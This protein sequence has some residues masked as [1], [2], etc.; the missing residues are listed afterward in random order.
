MITAETLAK[1]GYSEEALREKF[2]PA[3]GAE[4]D[5][6]IKD[7]CDLMASRIRGAVDMAS[8]TAEI[9]F[10]VDEAIQTPLRQLGYTLARHFHE[11]SVGGVVSMNDVASIA[12]DWGF[13]GMIQPVL[14]ETG[15]PLSSRDGNPIYA[16]DLPI[17]TNIFFPAVL[18]YCTAQWANLFN[19][20]D[21]HPLYKYPPAI[22]TPKNKAKCDILTSRADRMTRDMGYR[23]DERQA[24]WQSVVYGSCLKVPREPYYRHYEIVGAETQVDP[25]DPTKTVTVPVKRIVREGVRWSLAHPT[26]TIMDYAH[27][28]STVNSDT[29]AEFYGTYEIY[30]WGDVKKNKEFWLDTERG[31]VDRVVGTSNT[32]FHS[33]S[34]QRM[35]NIL[36]PC[37]MKFPDWG[38]STSTDREEWAHDFSTHQDDQGVPLCNVYVKLIPKQYGLFD[39][40][41]PMWMRWVS[42]YES[43]PILV[44]PILYTPGVLYQY[45]PDQNA[46]RP[47]SL[48]TQIIPFSDQIGNMITQWIMTLKRNLVNLIFFNRDGVDS[49]V[50]DRLRKLGKS[51]FSS[52][53]FEGVSAMALQTAGTSIRELFGVVA[54][55]PGNTDEAIRGINMMIM[56]ME[57]MLG[58]SAQ[59]AGATQSHQV[60]ATEASTIKAAVEERRQ[61][62]SGGLDSA[63]EATRNRLYGAI[64]A[65]SSDDIFEQVS[66]EMGYDPVALEELGFS[67]Q[68]G[69][70][71]KK[72]GV[73]GPK[74]ALAAAEFASDQEGARRV[75]DITLA[76]EMLQMFQSMFAN[77]AIIETAGIPKLIDW[78]NTIAVYAGLPPNLRLS[79]GQEKPQQ[80]V[81]PE[82][83]N[84]QIAQ[85]A[86]QVTASQME[87]V[88]R[89]VKERMMDPMKDDITKAIS[90]IAKRLSRLEGHASAAEV[91]SPS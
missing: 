39:Y 45:N 77:R 87:E 56:I 78:F 50:I 10:A 9:Y 68:P 23:D 43:K 6:K 29:G 55:P 24:I 16:I 60:S 13:A 7:L 73:A 17:F 67:V 47:V 85:I 86:S 59:E 57:R 37:Q 34:V 44:Q 32:V 14:D 2:I 65:Y 70:D 54:F 33:M 42:A 15:K 88:G 84:Q 21:V 91:S 80:Q 53:N 4:P 52:L 8:Q 28:P 5:Q 20:R 26:K 81:D 66:S 62:T 90:E 18:S 64:M 63:F 3:D 76:R 40:D 49:S 69:Y 79:P 12:E 72:V 31:E 1:L 83:L 74:S 71:G 51:A 41:E 48:A 46:V 25:A 75:S 61:L 19:V 30:R 36:Y 58:F 22:P 35:L 89:A 11:A 27:R 38:R 82:A